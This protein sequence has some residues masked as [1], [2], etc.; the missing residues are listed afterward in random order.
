MSVSSVKRHAN[1]YAQTRSAELEKLSSDDLYGLF[2][3]GGVPIFEEIG[4]LVAGRLLA[5]NPEAPRGS[6]VLVALTFDNPMSRWV[7]KAF[8]LPFDED[9]KGKGVNL[10]QNRILPRRFRFRT[11]IDKAFSDQEL[12]LRLEYPAPSLIAGGF[13]DIR[14]IEE[15]V[16]LG[17]AC[18]RAPWKKVPWFF[19]Y[20][21]ILSLE[22]GETPLR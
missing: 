10:F 8:T 21:V 19:R 13:D 5:W 20:F 12:C 1:E 2:K 22:P 17:Q 11:S 3:E 6:K 16:F 9:R 7:G 18:Y 15:G 14:K 4:G